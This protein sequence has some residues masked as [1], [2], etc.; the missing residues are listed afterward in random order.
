[1]KKL[2]LLAFVLGSFVLGSQAQVRRHSDTTRQVTMNNPRKVNDKLKNLNLTNEQKEKLKE[3]R[4]DG[5][6]KKELIMNNSSLTQEQKKE[7]LKELK[8]NQK[9]KSESILTPEQKEKVKQGKENWGKG[10]KG[11]NLSDEQKEKMKGIKEES[12]TKKT[13]I[14]NN[15]TLSDTQKKEQLKDLKK[16]QKNKVSQVLTAEQKTK[17]KNSDK[18]PHQKK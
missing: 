7:Q 16:D 1:M 15:T 6:Q 18:K 4:Q 8:K 9:E 13:E 2:F 10:N 5:K 3:L 14:M 12:K 17:I 11:L